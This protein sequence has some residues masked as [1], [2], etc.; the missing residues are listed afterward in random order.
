MGQTRAVGW[1]AGSLVVAALAAAACSGGGGG[2]ASPP[3]STSATTATPTSAAAAS[4]TTAAASPRYAEGDS[5][6][7]FDQTKLHEFRI[8]VPADSLAT[9]DADPS[10]EEYVEG[11]LTFDGE[12]LT[13]VG[14]RYKGSVGAFVGCTS[15]P[16][17]L[18]PSG[19]KTCTKLSL[20][21]KIDYRQPGREFYGVR[22]V[23]LHS[24]NL[25]PS[26]MHERLGYWLFRE[27]GVP[28]PRSTH[29]RVV[30][31]GE[32]VGVFGLTEEIDGRFTRRAFDD[33]KGN[34]YKEVWPFDGTGAPTA[35]STFV[36]ALETNEDDA[37]VNADLI[38][39]F[40][41]ELAAAAPADRP[42]VIE[43]WTDVDA[44]LASIVVDRAIRHDDGPLHWYCGGARGCGPHNFF[45]YEDPTAKRVWLVPWDLD[46]AFA[47]LSPGSSTVGDFIR[48]PDPFG[49]ITADCQPFTSGRFGLQQRSA[50]CDPLLGALAGMN[51]KYDQI[52]ARLLA[53]PM[54]PERVTEQLHA[55][56]AQIADSVAD[57]AAK[58]SDAPSVATWKVA[59]DTLRTSIE[60]SRQG[61]GR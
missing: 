29:A 49:Q 19:P 58:H 14:V 4:T 21:V 12:T 60:A 8:D 41:A 57:A 43:R 38:T 36:A 32:F 53:G 37:G 39:T 35:A 13:G 17:P 34:L 31:N 2:D 55:W 9:L 16:N 61:T 54:S 40:A 50:A 22:H 59:V 10:A 44:L 7:L 11:S 48:I 56:T 47:A 15:G 24:Q 18:T 27:M 30:V 3:T 26:M 25:D 20:K 51:E 1:L 52:R 45:W 46:N 5:E 42:A 23:L 33:G 6:E 28:A